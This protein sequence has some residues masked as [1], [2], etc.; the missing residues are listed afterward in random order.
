MFVSNTI[1]DI[2]NCLTPGMTDW[3][4][5]KTVTAEF[6]VALL[7]DSRIPNSSASNIDI[8]H[9]KV[10]SNV[11]RRIPFCHFVTAVA[12]LNVRLSSEASE[13]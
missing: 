2:R 13:K 4:S 12:L 1:P 3:E 5:R 6:A 10:C 11:S 8:V 7:T 9:E